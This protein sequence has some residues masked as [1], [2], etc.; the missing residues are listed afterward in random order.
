MIGSSL[1]ILYGMVS[2]LG[3]VA[4]L[5]QGTVKS[6][7][8]YIYL[9][10]LCHIVLVVITVYDL[11]TPLNFIWFIIGFLACL[12]S[13]WLNGT[14]VFGRNNWFHYFIVALL[15]ALAYFLT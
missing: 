7:V 14:F 10:L 8:G 1:L 4:N 5:I 3:A 13:R 12:T 2:A 11:C 15:F 9:F 6:A